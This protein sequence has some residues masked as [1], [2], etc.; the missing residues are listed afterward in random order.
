M[1]SWN[2]ARLC[3]IFSALVGVHVHVWDGKEVGKQEDWEYQKIV[4]MVTRYISE[5]IEKPRNIS[6]R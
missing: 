4:P 3:I 5:N 1:K 2:E 6:I